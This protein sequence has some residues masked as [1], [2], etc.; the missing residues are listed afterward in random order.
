MT[1]SSLLELQELEEEIGKTRDDRDRFFFHNGDA[2]EMDRDEVMTKRIERIYERALCVEDTTGLK[3][4]MAGMALNLTDEYD[5]RCEDCLSM[6][7][8][9]LPFDARGWNELGQCISK[10]GDDPS[11][12]VSLF[13]SSV[14]LNRCSYSL[15]LLSISIRATL[16]AL[17]PNEAALARAESIGLAREATELDESCGDGWMSLANA[18][19]A[20]F[21]FDGQKNNHHLEESVRSYQKAIENGLGYKSDLH[22]NV[23]TAL[24]YE[25]DLEKALHHL[26]VAYKCDRSTVILEQLNE[27]RT[28]LRKT[29]ECIKDCDGDLS[30]N[31]DGSVDGKIIQICSPPSFTPCLVV[32]SSSSS[33]SSRCI[34]ALLNCSSSLSLLVGDTLSISSSERLKYGACSLFRVGS[35]STVLRNGRYL[36]DGSLALSSVSI[37]SPSSP[38]LP[39][40]RRIPPSFS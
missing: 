29:D 19:L 31:E 8:R 3:Y 23:S 16:S 14:A 1:G 5:E 27:L 37:E 4:L 10:R 12:V 18:L 28:I 7:V 30:L 33:P 25:C 6:A 38:C 24:R 40:H 9:L 17:S 13:S 36:R 22:L 34:V 35:P 26:E 21:F 39:F 2:T 20:T 11:L 15:A 32:L